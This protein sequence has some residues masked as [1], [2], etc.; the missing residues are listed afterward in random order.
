MFA[1]AFCQKQPQ[2]LA[3]ESVEVNT[4][5]V[6]VTRHQEPKINTKELLKSF[7]ENS[8]IGVP[9]K[10]KIELSLFEGAKNNV[11]E[12]KFYSL[13]KN[14]E[15]NSKQ[16]VQLENYGALPLN[17]E[18]KDFN[19]DGFKD[20]T[21]VSGIAARG[22]NEIRNL[23]IYDKTK[24]ELV[25]IKNSGDYPNL[26]Y[27]KELNCIDAHIFTGSSETVFLKFENDTLK[28]FAS[29]ETSNTV[30][31]RNVYLIDKSG[32]KKLLRTDKISEDNL[33]ERYKTFDPPKPYTS[34]ELEQ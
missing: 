8:K 5:T 14:K 16:T 10:N 27:N 26:L 3:N 4:N 33:F 31:A 23:L 2:T 7:T 9:H 28:E 18:L 32:N 20:L 17:A 6:A 34:R 12:L 21:Y 19:N 1:A 29:V 25:Y 22:A 11:V 15:W 13:G 30:N 24:D